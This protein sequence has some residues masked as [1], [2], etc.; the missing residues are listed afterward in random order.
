M[1][2][3]LMPTPCLRSRS[4]LSGVC[5]SA[6][7]LV[8][9]DFHVLSIVGI[10][11]RLAF[12]LPWIWVLPVWHASSRG[13]KRLDP[14]VGGFAEPHQGAKGSSFL[15]MKWRTNRLGFS[16]FCLPPSKI[17]NLKVGP[18]KKVLRETNLEPTEQAR[19][20]M[21]TAFLETCAPQRL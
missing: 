5:Q 11:G 20:R 10:L 8:L 17:K 21:E 6:P 4:H 15:V 9:L 12:S 18:R 19:D 3:G 1:D 2:L 13:K 16:M 14:S 7:L